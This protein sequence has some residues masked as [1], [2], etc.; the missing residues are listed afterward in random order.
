[1]NLREV[2]NGVINTCLEVGEFIRKEGANFDRERIEQ[3]N[4]F[5]NLVSYVDKEAERRLVEALHKIL[6]QAGF[7]TEE[8]TVEQSKDLLCILLF[9]PDSIV[10]ERHHV[11]I[12]STI[13]ADDIGYFLRFDQPILDIDQWFSY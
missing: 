1:M 3:K 4:G 10:L 6:P 9:K 2:E 7:I 5:N 12:L 13:E 11:I 8:G